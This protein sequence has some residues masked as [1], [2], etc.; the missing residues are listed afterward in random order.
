MSSYILAHD[1]GTTGDKAT[2]FNEEGRLVASEF[3]AYGTIYPKAGWAEQDPEDY[4]RAFC[5]ST[6]AIIEHSGI[7]PDDIA[8]VCFSGQMMAA[9]PVDGKGRPLRNSIIWADL[10]AT[11][12]ASTI[13]ER[14]GHKR[15]YTISGNSIS[16]SYPAAKIMWIMRNEPDIYRRTCKFLGAKDFVGAKLTGSLVSDY[17]EASA[18]ALLNITSL[19]WADE[20]VS[21]AEIDRDK[22]PDLVESTSVIGRVKAAPADE[23]G[24]KAGTAVVKGAGDGPCATAGA[25]VVSDGESYFYLGTST[26]MGLA[27]RRPYLDPEMRTHTFCH[28]EKGLYAPAGA[29]QSGG[30]SVQWLKDALCGHEAR[31]AEDIGIDVYDILSMR[32]E[33]APPGCFGLIFLPYL[34]GERCPFWNPNARGCFIGLSIVHTKD[35]IIRAV[36]EGVAY[37]MKLIAEAFEQQGADH[38]SIRMIG[39]GAKS[40]LWCSIFADVMEKDIVVLD[41]K[42]EATSIGAAIAGGVGVGMFS[43]IHEADRFVKIDRKVQARSENSGVYR[44][45]YDIFQMSYRKL[46]ILFPKLI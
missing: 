34:M 26:W 21:A 4:W 2:L 20:I 7:K 13:A 36:F 5:R 40:A 38:S 9:L 35:H 45:Y 31:Q 37:N 8:A 6:K 18:M 24:L 22:L 43:S 10:R 23:C 30:G 17:S 25:G 19:N 3:S 39:G 32:A 15:F 33:N 41:H 46:S 11:K 29:M 44:K 42:E 1:L 12:E 28:F 16:A 14:I 27:S